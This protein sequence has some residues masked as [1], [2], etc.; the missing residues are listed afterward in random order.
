MWPAGSRPLFGCLWFEAASTEAVSLNIVTPWED[1]ADYAVELEGCS[2]LS[3]YKA[4]FDV[5]RKKCI[6]L[7]VM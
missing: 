7:S 2:F 6:N 4:V 3:Y 1:S 5:A